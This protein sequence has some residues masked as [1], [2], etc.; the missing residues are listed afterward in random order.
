M[1]IHMHYMVKVI[2]LS[3]DAYS[4]LK[5]AK[6]GRSF[7][8]TVLSLVEGKPEKKLID[9]FGK[10]PGGAEEMAAIGELFAS[11]R[12]KFKTRDVTF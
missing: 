4:K 5:R 2:S 10:W 3:E 1:R 6:N 8:E 11:D 12:K 9:Y 7:S